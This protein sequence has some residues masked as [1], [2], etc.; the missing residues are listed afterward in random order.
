MKIT[1]IHVS[2]GDKVRVPGYDYETINP[3]VGLTATVEDGESF[4]AAYKKLS[5]LVNDI[6][7]KE[8]GI[9]MSDFIEARKRP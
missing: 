6:W 2:R 5:Q 1:T 8:A 9:Q 7:S 3:I 4:A